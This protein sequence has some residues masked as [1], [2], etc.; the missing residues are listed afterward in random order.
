MPVFRHSLPFTTVD[1]DGHPRSQ[2]V[3]CLVISAGA[4]LNFLTACNETACNEEPDPIPGLGDDLRFLAHAV[5]GVN[6]WVRAGRVVPRLWRKGPTWYAQW[7]LLGGG[8]QRVWLTE[9]LH[10]MPPELAH[11]GGFAAV[12]SFVCLLYT[13]PSPRD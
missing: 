11:N 8:A 10:A 3:P 12:E 2:T 1:S 4:A 13:S 6:Q 5:A 9:L 7:Q